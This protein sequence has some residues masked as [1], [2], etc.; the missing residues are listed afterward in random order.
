MK[1]SSSSW[2]LTS[3]I[4]VIAL[5]IG[6]G[7]G[8][9][10]QPRTVTEF[11]HST[12]LSAPRDIGPFRL[13]K[14]DGTEFNRD[15]FTGKWTF[16]F[17]GYTHCPDVCPN[18]MT[19]FNIMD[20]ALQDKPALKDKTSFIMVSV[21]PGR[22]TVAVMAEYVPYFNP[23]F[24][25]LTETQRGNLLALTSQLGIV[26]FV[27]KP[28]KESDPYIVDHSPS[29]ILVNPQGQ[30]HAVFSAPHDPAGM[31]A[32]FNTIAKQYEVKK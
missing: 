21:D 8:L 10:Q 29:I 18:T 22:D 28:V 1:N 20:K 6:I 23:R 13:S 5:A 17:F 19:V 4:I 31:L 27:K 25:G 24:I 30:F 32:D 12:V 15:N 2:P 11:E 16:M 26:S 3:L 14:Q 9:Y 7:I